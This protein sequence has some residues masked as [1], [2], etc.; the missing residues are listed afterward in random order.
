MNRRDTAE[1]LLRFR[2]E[3]MAIECGV[4]PEV[5]IASAENHNLIRDFR[6]AQIEVHIHIEGDT[7]PLKIAQMLQAAIEES[8]K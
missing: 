7:S 4:S 1:K 8:A 6:E 2:L 5:L 3:R